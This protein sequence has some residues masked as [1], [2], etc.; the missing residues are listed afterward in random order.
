MGTITPVPFK[1]GEIV[2]LSR[3]FH[4]ESWRERD[5]KIVG[6]DECGP[7]DAFDCILNLEA[8]EGNSERIEVSGAWIEGPLRLRNYSC[9]LEINSIV[10]LIDL[11]SGE[12][13]VAGKF[14]GSKKR[15]DVNALSET[16]LLKVNIEEESFLHSS[17][18]QQC[19]ECRVR[20]T[21][22]HNPKESPQTF[23][24]ARVPPPEDTKPPVKIISFDEI[25]GLKKQV[26][27]LSSLL[28][29]PET[30]RKWGTKPANKILL[31]GPPGTGKTSLI[32]ILASQLNVPLFEINLAWI[33]SKW[34]G[35][36][37]QRL[38][39]VFDRARNTGRAIIFIDE[40]DAL[41]RNRD[42]LNII[43]HKLLSVFLTNLDGLNSNSETI[44]LAATNKVELID[45]AL[46]RP[47][48][49]DRKMEVPLPTPKER[50]E[51][52]EI[53]LMKANQLASQDLFEKDIDW[54][55]VIEQ[56]RLFSG[57][58][59]AEVIRRTL[60]NKIRLQQLLD[61]LE[62][63]YKVKPPLV[64]ADNILDAIR[65]IVTEKKLVDS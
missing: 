42:D 16:C 64:N 26:G 58:E 59:I 46:L 4:T 48:R 38:Q 35:E 23:E 7:P 29:D 24:V 45:P 41:A 60:E 32:R 49:F 55:F 61:G 34:Y 20:D 6:I 56:S 5:C 12:G 9:S 3:N 52:F 63:K 19:K 13:H 25:G 11:P 14:L 8:L 65:E 33:L 10:N 18:C 40:I 62:L 50:K 54:N 2:R 30:Y 44:V 17:Y 51:I 1:I 27:I 21:G 53:Y 36:S 43:D 28:I 57:A 39:V 22:G 31:Y 37:E 15:Y 47:G